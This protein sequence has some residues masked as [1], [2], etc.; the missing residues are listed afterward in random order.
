MPRTINNNTLATKPTTG[1]HPPRSHQR[2]QNHRRHQHHPCP[3]RH[4]GHR[5]Q[6]PHQQHHLQPTPPT[7]HPPRQSHRNQPA[8][9]PEHRPLTTNTHRP[10]PTTSSINNIRDAVNHSN[11]RNHFATGITDGTTD[12]AT[13]PTATRSVNDSH[14]G[15]TTRYDTIGNNETKGA[16]ANAPASNANGNLRQEWRGPAPT[17]RT[18][19]ST[20]ASPTTPYNANTHS[21]PG[22]A[23]TNIVT[24]STDSGNTATPPPT[25]SIDTLDHNRCNT[26][27][28]IPK[29]SRRK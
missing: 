21:F 17:V 5:L 15:Y 2:H 27:H 10:T 7:A 29:D 19:P 18:P 12:S 16:R 20:R 1:R 26:Y 24:S 4:P 9:T 6:H 11:A 14:H 3:R 13:S 25:H 8:P 22:G 23:L 28:H